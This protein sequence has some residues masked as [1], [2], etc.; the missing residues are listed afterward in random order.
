MSKAEQLIYG[1]FP[2]RNGRFNPAGRSSIDAKSNRFLKNASS[3]KADSLVV[4]RQ[5]KN[6]DS[7]FMKST[8]LLG[9][10]V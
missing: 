4:L 2:S 6:M 7:K 5:A 8:D 3:R 10:Y 9:K 1:E